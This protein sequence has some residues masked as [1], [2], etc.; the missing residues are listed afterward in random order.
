MESR[1]IAYEQKMGV[2]EEDSCEGEFSFYHYEIIIFKKLL[3]EWN[4]IEWG[5]FIF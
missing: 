5:D 1:V 2:R 3:K 4:R